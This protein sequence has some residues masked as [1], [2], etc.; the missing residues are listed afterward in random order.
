MINL[1]KQQKL[2]NIKIN[3]DELGFLV[4]QFSVDKIEF[5]EIMISIQL[6]ICR[7]T[8]CQKYVAKKIEKLKTYIYFTDYLNLEQG[9][10]ANNT[11]LS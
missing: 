2:S 11:I 6:K 5:I 7:I 3:T 4:C 8:L 10:A 9:K 1:Y